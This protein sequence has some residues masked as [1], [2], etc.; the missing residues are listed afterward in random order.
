M[1]K[2]K[3]VVCESCKGDVSLTDCY[4]PLCGAKF[5]DK[6]LKKDNFNG[7]DSYSD[8][9]GGKVSDS[10]DSEKKKLVELLVKWGN[11]EGESKKMVEKH[12]EYV[13]RVYSDAPRSRKA[14]VIRSLW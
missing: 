11:N 5:V 4:C 1:E 12:F 9:D 14:E 7:V 6:L 8:P 13:Q 2:V 3:K 10:D